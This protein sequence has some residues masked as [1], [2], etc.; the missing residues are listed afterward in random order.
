ML[1]GLSTVTV[2]VL[3]I[4]EFVN[5]FLK[6]LFHILPNQL[7]PILRPLIKHRPNRHNH[8]LC[9]I[10]IYHIPSIAQSSIAS[11]L[12]IN[13]P[14]Q[15]SIPHF[16]PS[17]LN[18]R[19]FLN[20][21]LRHNLSSIKTS[22]IQIQLS[23]LHHISYFQSK[24]PASRIHSLRVSNPAF[25]ILFLK[26]RKLLILIPEPDI[27][28]HHN[29]QRCKQLFRGKFQHRFSCHLNMYSCQNI[30]SNQRCISK[31]PNL[32]RPPRWSSAYRT[33]SSLV[34]NSV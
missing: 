31:L 9:L 6:H 4:T 28:V 32:T 12:L 33:Q 26:P 13:N 1:C 3:P 27:T 24:P 10:Y 25:H 15:I 30:W 16:L 34:K 18:S 8:L 22:P 19:T 20:P 23:N 5:F 14:P 11:F 21:I 17:T 7:H 29:D 2:T